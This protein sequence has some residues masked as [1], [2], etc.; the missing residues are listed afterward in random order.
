MFRRRRRKGS[1]AASVSSRSGSTGSASS[2][3]SGAAHHPS[4]MPAGAAEDDIEAALA[5]Q[6][7]RITAIHDA[8]E[9]REV[10]AGK[11]WKAA[12]APAMT[13]RLN[14]QREVLRT[15]RGKLEALEERAEK[16][17]SEREEEGAE[18]VAGSSG[19][20]GGLQRASWKAYAKLKTEEANAEEAMDATKQLLY[21]PPHEG[22]LYRLG[23][24]GGDA[25]STKERGV[26]IGMGDVFVDMIDASMHM[27]VKPAGN[28]GNGAGPSKP[29]I[30]VALGGTASMGSARVVVHVVN[31][32]LVGE[33]RKI[34]NLKRSKISGEVELKADM[35]AVYEGGGKGWKIA[36]GS[37]FKVTN[38]GK[39][40]GT[41]VSSVRGWGPVCVCVC[42]CGACASLLESVLR[43]SSLVNNE[44]ILTTTAIEP[45]RIPIT[46]SNSLTNYP[47]HPPH[48][49]TTT[50]TGAERGAETRLESHLAGCPK[51][52]PP[53]SAAQRAGGDA[54]P[55]RLRLVRALELP[56]R[57]AVRRRAHHRRI[58]GG[59]SE[60]GQPYQPPRHDY[61]RCVE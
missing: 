26:F 9:A 23:S 29:S 25:K 46:L 11:E 32:K 20:S 17:S 54:A 53:R 6:Y 37:T 15:I 18:K 31:F 38:L 30:R 21:F 7:S 43:V 45:H 51:A 52:G 2:T 60:E 39:T 34:P 12:H 44:F 4:M 58:R 59:L 13:H 10:A 28:A 40:K 56:R 19:S 24:T 5:D 61:G 47:T 57:R 3:G 35:R 16:R 8:V 50:A 14:A 42:V 41:H 55:A 33:S 36:D 49:T 27:E 48:L 22:W 1:E